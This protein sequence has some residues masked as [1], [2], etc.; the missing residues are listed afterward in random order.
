MSQDLLG[1]LNGREIKLEMQKSHQHD[2]NTEFITLWEGLSV[3]LYTVAHAEQVSHKFQM[4]ELIKEK[5]QTSCVICG[6]NGE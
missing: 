4:I 5:S 2:P 6:E 1:R 3:G